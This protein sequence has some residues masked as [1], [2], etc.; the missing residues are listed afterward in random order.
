MKLK[1]RISLLF[2][3]VSVFPLAI[4]ISIT[5]FLNANENFRAQRNFLEEYALSSANSLESFFN[6]KSSL[7]NTYAQLYNNGMTNWEEYQEVVKIA[8]DESIFEKVILAM[9]D[10]T[11]YNTG[12]GNPNFG[13]KQTSKNDSPEAT[14]SSIAARDYF[15]Y[16]VTTN[17][18]AVER[19]KISDP[20]ISLSNKAKQVLVAQTIFDSNGDVA[21]I[22]AGSVSFEG[23]DTYLE[24]INRDLLAQFSEDS[25]LII[26][27][28]TGNF[29]YHWLAEKNIHVETVNGK[30][31]SIVSNIK[32]EDPAFLD[33]SKGILEGKANK[34]GRASCRESV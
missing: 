9:K 29:V 4:V 26:V 18:R 31:V 20:V 6:E 22:I 25:H 19:R 11:Y 23:L 5:A 1:T 34:I 32:D 7:I 24:E 17:T 10:G 3:F 33:V 16:L 8:V 14:L 30:E 12:G 15:Q 28:D 13:G 21:G 2:I 27:S